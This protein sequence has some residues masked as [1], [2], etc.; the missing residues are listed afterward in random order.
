MKRTT[1][2]AALGLGAIAAMLSPLASAADAGWYLGGNIGLAKATIDDERIIDGLLAG[3]FATPSIRDDEKDLGY[4]LY[5]GYQFNRY[6]AVEGGY[7]NLGKFSFDADTV[8]AGTLSGQIKLQGVN[9][10]AV[11]TLPFTARFSAFGRIGVNY[12]Q[13]KDRFAGS[14]AAHVLD[15][16]RRERGAN[17]KFGLGLEYDLTPYL[18]LRLEGE[19]YRVDDAVGNKGDID[20]A[21]LGLVY[22]FGAAEPAPAPLPAAAAPAVAAA[23]PPAEPVR[24]NVSFEA[25][26]LFDFDQSE[27]KPEG[28]QALDRFAAELGATRYDVVHVT[29]YTDRIGSPDYNLALSARRAES[30]KAYLAESAG[31][32]A[33]KISAEGRN[34]A[35]PVT[36][37][38]DCQGS[39]ATPQ[40]I[41]CLQPDRRVEVEVNGSK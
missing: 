37:T 24:R 31:I 11:G 19:R 23:A 38:G 41:A 5:G 14:G 3:G 15:P 36:Q 2:T 39:R 7:F 33:A 16:T 18:S 27:L 21:S 6:F 32:P 20:L 9:L 34:S 35:D 40:L 25:S 22:R 13:A 30:V 10:D 26:S 17:Y 29:G 4:K 8:P 1:K 28:R 12:A